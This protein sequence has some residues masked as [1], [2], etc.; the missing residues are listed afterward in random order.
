[1]DSDASLVA[2][3]AAAAFL[4]A[5]HCDFVFDDTL[6]IVNNRD[7]APDSSFTELWTHDFWGK[8]LSAF[9]SHKSYRPLTILSFRA[10]TLIAHPAQPAAF[11]AVNVALHAA[12]SY[13]VTR[14]ASKLW[15]RRRPSLAPR[16]RHVAL[17][18][19]L[20]FAVHPVHV[21]AVTGTVGRAELLCALGCF[22]SASAYAAC[23]SPAGGRSLFARCAL[24]VLAYVRAVCF[25]SIACSASMALSSSFV[26]VFT[27][28]RVNLRVVAIACNSSRTRTTCTC[29]ESTRLR[30]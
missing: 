14:L 26:V 19:G 16:Q 20:L 9:D 1:M 8:P 24:G 4:N 10:Q 21:E 13:C 17:L 28:S 15:P 5:I 22:A 3:V 29:T 6:A 18:A 7:V 27:S 23:A 30:A 12:V 25:P 11:H 2:A